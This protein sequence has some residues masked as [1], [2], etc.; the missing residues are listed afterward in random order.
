VSHF[1]PL[2][3]A[4]FHDCYASMGHGYAGLGSANVRKSTTPGFNIGSMSPIFRSGVALVRSFLSLYL[5]EPYDMRPSPCAYASPH[6]YYSIKEPTRGLRTR[7]HSA[8]YIQILALLGAVMAFLPCHHCQAGEF[9]GTGTRPS[10]SNPKNKLDEHVE[11]F[12]ADCEIC[13]K[14]QRHVD[15]VESTR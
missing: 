13:D 12:L 2:C 6:I 15:H 3:F 11:V 8:Q 10:L 9:P 7:K 14:D 5:C 4:I 1:Q